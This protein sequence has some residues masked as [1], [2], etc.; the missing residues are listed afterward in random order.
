M[1]T[2]HGRAAEGR[3][4]WEAMHPSEEPPKYRMDFPTAGGIQN[5]PVEGCPGRA[6]TRTT[7]RVH[8]SH[9]N[10]WDTVIIL[11]EEN[12]PH[13]RSP[14]CNMLLPWNALNMRH[15]DTVQCTKG[16]E[17]KQRRLVEEDP[18]ESLERDF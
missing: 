8:S 15:L 16:A 12:P 17:M 10:V 4:R 1:Q 14:C 5:C 9:R 13:L 7:I 6:A 18:R 11:D 3:R 2:Q